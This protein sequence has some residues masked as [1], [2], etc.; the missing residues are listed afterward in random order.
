VG[1]VD[2][3]WPH[4]ILKCSFPLFSNALAVTGLFI[5][6]DNFRGSP[7]S[8]L[9]NSRFHKNAFATDSHLYFKKSTNYGLKVVFSAEAD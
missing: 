7:V 5:Q 4:W 6:D 8:L 2:F 3:Y 1:L 9:Q